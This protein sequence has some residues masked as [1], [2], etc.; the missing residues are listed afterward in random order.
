MRMLRNCVKCNQC[1]GS[2]L[3]LFLKIYIW[4]KSHKWSQNQI[5]IYESIISQIMLPRLPQHLE[6]LILR[7]FNST[8]K[9]LPCPEAALLMT[10]STLSYVSR[11]LST[12]LRRQ[13]IWQSSN[14]KK[15]KK[16]QTITWFNK[17]FEQSIFI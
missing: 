2:H 16:L 9:L 13:T 4:F 1:C 8:C 17:L 3:T 12:N 5:T 7:I 6:Y 14:Y 11:T 10:T 15:C